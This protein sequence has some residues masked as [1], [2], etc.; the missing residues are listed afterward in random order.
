[1]KTTSTPK[2][3]LFPQ[4]ET[5]FEFRLTKTSA[6]VSAV[7]TERRAIALLGL[8]PCDALALELLAKA[9][10]EHFRLP[11]FLSLVFLCTEAN[12]ECF[13]TAVGLSPWA[14]HAGDIVF[15]SEDGAY[16]AKTLTQKGKACLRRYCKGSQELSGAA[17]DTRAEKFAT[18]LRAKLPR[19]ELPAVTR[20]Q[21]TARAWERFAERCIECGVCTYLCPL[22]YCFD[23][24][25]ECAGA[26]ERKGVR[27]RTWDSCM[28]AEFTLQ[29]S[30]YNPRGTT[31]ARLQNRLLH[32]FCDFPREHQRAGCTGCGRCVRLCPMGID[33]R[34]LLQE[35]A[36]EGSR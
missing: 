20:M 4:T 15:L 18:A 11:E 26:L 36:R 13:C 8:A 2:T 21:L 16:L 24:A 3:L 19:K 7:R 1:V 6:E 25:D 17:W 14:P 32:K 33:I 28:Y 9:L 12:A 29:A 5:L 31:K 35:L 27:V 22:C 10:A 23:I 34:E 30:G